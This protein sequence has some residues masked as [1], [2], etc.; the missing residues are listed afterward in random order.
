MGSLGCV[1]SV[2]VIRV[3]VPSQFLW[4]SQCGYHP[5]KDLAKNAHMKVIVLSRDIIFL[6]SLFN[7]LKEYFEN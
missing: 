6:T 3:L 2:V 1:G 4:C 7:H 5:W